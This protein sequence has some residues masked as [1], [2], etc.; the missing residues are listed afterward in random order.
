MA[1]ILS[2]EVGI[3]ISVNRVVVAELY[4]LFERVVDEDEADEGREAFLCETCEVLHQEAGI[5]GH[6]HQTEYS[7]PEADPQ[8]KLKVV[9][10]IVSEEKR[11]IWHRE[12]G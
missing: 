10:A 2:D 1:V 6:Q 8:P 4:H 11:Q 7:R 12:T 9:Q 5:C 3:V